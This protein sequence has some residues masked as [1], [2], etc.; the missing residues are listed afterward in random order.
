MSAALVWL[1]CVW[2]VLA[3]ATAACQ[4]GRPTTAPSMIDHWM[5]EPMHQ[6]TDTQVSRGQLIDR[7]ASANA[8]A[9]ANNDSQ[10][11]DHSLDNACNGRCVSEQA[12]DGQA[13]MHAST[14]PV[15]ALQM[16]TVWSPLPDTILL[17][18]TDMATD[19]TGSVWPSSTL[20]TCIN[21]SNPIQSIFCIP[22]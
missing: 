5:D 15:S 17:P 21:P 1:G 3:V 16:R 6:C 7:V 14:S 4:A 18:S 11:H 22:D 10:P 20:S 8:N 9:A 2:L 13:G 19:Q 12:A